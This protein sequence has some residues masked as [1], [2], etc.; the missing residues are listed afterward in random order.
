[1]F[2]YWLDGAN[3]DMPCGEGDM[4]TIGP[5]HVPTMAPAPAALT[6]GAPFPQGM[7][8]QEFARV[9]LL[10]VL[11]SQFIFSS[12]FLLSQAQIGF[13]ARDLKKLALNRF[14]GVSWLSM[15]LASSC[16]RATT[17]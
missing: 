11:K 16:A 8:I 12:D 9:V 6:L 13:S 14:F 5:V 4:P 15:G 2:L 17:T 10:D 1:M 3:F 7:R